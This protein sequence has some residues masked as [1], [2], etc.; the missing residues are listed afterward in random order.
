MI[1]DVYYAWMSIMLSMYKVYRHLF[2][3]IFPLT[4]SM[5][6]QENDINAQLGSLPVLIEEL[7]NRTD[8]QGSPELYMLW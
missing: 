3:D 2:A 4:F 1:M 8:Y 5:G 6:L 7:N